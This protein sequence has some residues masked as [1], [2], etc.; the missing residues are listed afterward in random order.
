MSQED[1]SVAP[2]GRKCLHVPSG[3]GRDSQLG[4]RLGTSLQCSSLLLLLFCFFRPPGNKLPISSHSHDSKLNAC[5]PPIGLRTSIHPDPS[6]KIT[7]QALP[8]QH[9]S[10]CRPK[11]DRS[12][13]GEHHHFK[14]ELARRR[15]CVHM[16]VF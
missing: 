13:Q 11:R 7:V 16:C 2:E 6:I 1:L 14:R 4:V 3:E 15:K 12:T 9:I 10:P 5:P 8:S